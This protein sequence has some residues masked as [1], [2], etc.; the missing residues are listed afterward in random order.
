MSL[1]SPP[2]QWI[3]WNAPEKDCRVLHDLILTNGYT[4]ALEIGTSTGRS[5]IWIARALSETGGR[6]VTI[7]RDEGRYHT[8]LKNF[9]REGL[10]RIIDARLADAHRL[11][12]ELKTRFDFVFSD[13]DKDWYMN[14]FVAVSSLLEK[15]GCFAAHN[16]LWTWDSG[17]IKF[18]DYVQGLSNFSTTI[19][20]A[21]QE[22]ISISY[23][24]SE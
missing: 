14:Y 1:R 22:G 2:D 15:G 12:A 6:L 3:Y 7:E 16:V 19:N 24:L 8:A 11:V 20:K 10:D 5:T 23:K 13:A 21:S 4:N 18:L 9:K 17:I